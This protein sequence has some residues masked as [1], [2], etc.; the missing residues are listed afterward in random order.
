[1]AGVW[2]EFFGRVFFGFVFWLLSALEEDGESFLSVLCL[3]ELQFPGY[4]Q[5]GR[6]SHL[7]QTCLCGCMH[8][9]SWWPS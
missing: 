2:G 4:L 8:L 9:L 7:P 5:N 1:M 6:S 3:R